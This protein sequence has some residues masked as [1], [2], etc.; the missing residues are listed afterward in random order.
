[1]IQAIGL[2]SN[3]RQELPPA[4]DDLSFEA[5]RRP[6]H[7]APRRPR[8]RQDDGAPAHA[9]TPTG[10]WRHLLQRPPAAP[11]RPSRHA[12][13][14]CCWVTCRGTPRA[15]SAASSACCARRQAF[16]SAAP[17]TC[18]KSSASSACGDA[19]PRHPLARHGP[20]AR[21]RLRAAGG[22]AHA[23]ARRAHRRALRPRDAAGCTACCAPTRPRAARSCA[24]PPTPRR[25]PAPPTASSPSTRG[26]SSPT[27]RPPTSPAPDCAPASPCAAPHAARLAAA[28]DQGGP[29]RAAL[30]GGGR[31]GR[32]PA[33]RVRQH[34]RG[35][36]RDRVPARHPRPPTRRRDRRH[37]SRRR[38]PSASRFP[39]REPCPGP[40]ASGRGP[41]P[42]PDGSADRA[43]AAGGGGAGPGCRSP[44]RR[45]RLRQP[46]AAPA[47]HL[48]PPRSESAASPA[49]RA[50][51]GLRCRHR[52]SDRGR[53]ARLVRARRRT[54]GPC[55]PHS[56]A[57]PAGRLAA[58][59]AAAARGT[60]R[61]A[62]R[63]PSP[64]AT[65]SA[66]PRWR[67]TAAPCRAD[68]DCSSPSSSSPRPPGC[69]WPSSPWAATPKCSTSSTDGSWREFPRT[70]SR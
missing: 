10:P 18:S 9:R 44:G 64:S 22:P 52:V 61:R 67:P 45:C 50:A 69:C 38:S 58:G 31:R 47:S 66:T 1:M 15:P 35:R 16:P 17:T 42:G 62:A 24:P 40:S 70:G 43:R 55:R 32:Q 53:R 25:P 5:P 41:E 23:R 4:V 51:P 7:R 8:R 56:A 14:A 21:P 36:R 39:D 63:A 48:R 20:P 33:L 57:P 3:P 13:S 26:G 11:H 59:A 19:A 12:R 27:R 34:L 6:R 29:G 54:P 68:W 60:R 28:A 46:A 49:L 37:G 30:R 2:T 65:S